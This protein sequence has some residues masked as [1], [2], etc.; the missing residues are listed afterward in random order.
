MCITSIYLG[1]RSIQID[2]RQR[3]FWEKLN[4]RLQIQNRAARRI[5]I[6]LQRQISGFQ[7]KS[8]IADTDSLWN[9]YNGI[10]GEFISQF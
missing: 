6:Q 2:Y 8:L 7:Q 9:S 10:L 1:H 4:F 3:F 5:N